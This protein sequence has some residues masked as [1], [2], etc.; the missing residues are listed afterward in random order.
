[1]RTA[2]LRKQKVT[3][4]CMIFPILHYLCLICAYFRSLS[5]NVRTMSS[6][7]VVDS[8]GFQN[9]ATCGR[10]TGANF[11]DLCCNYLHERMQLFYHET[12]LTAPQDRYAQV[13]TL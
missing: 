3:L 11:E 7:V 5:S 12:T 2:D 1:M 4:G 10:Q 8:P 6:L 13:N 9:P